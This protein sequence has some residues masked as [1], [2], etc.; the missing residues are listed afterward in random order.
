MG[1]YLI[2]SVWF[3]EPTCAFCT[4]GSYASLSV[5]PSVWTGPKIRLDNNSYLR[6]YWTIYMV[7]YSFLSKIMLI[8]SANHKVGSLPT[9]SCIFNYITYSVII[10][11]QI[12]SIVKNCSKSPLRDLT[13]NCMWELI[14]PNHGCW[15]YIWRLPLSYISCV[16]LKVSVVCASFTLAFS[17]AM[18][19]AL[20]SPLSSTD[21]CD[22]TWK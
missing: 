12:T 18:S 21:V 2:F 15:Q 9:S 5:R 3:I 14:F 22:C 19:L 10:S 20:L 16:C 11:N 1:I 13:R 17:A 7:Y 8:T 6:K 4:V